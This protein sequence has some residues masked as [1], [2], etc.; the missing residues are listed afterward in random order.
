MAAGFLS[1]WF[2][3]KLLFIGGFLVYTIFASVVVRQTYLMTQTLEVG[4]ETTLKTFSWAYLV[5]AL[6]ILVAAITF[7]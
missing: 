1:I 6:A 2:L 7:L 3:V 5:L 4:L